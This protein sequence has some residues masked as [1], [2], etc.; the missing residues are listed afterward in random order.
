MAYASA[1][2]IRDEVH[3]DYPS[4]QALD[5]SV[6]G[7]LFLEFEAEDRDLAELDLTEYGKGLE[8]EDR[9]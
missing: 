6:Y 5:P 9:A 7:P 4:V 2:G 3:R 1:M 8:A